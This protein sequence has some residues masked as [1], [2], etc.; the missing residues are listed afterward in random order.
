MA[1][2]TPE[3]T[4]AV[5]KF[6]GLLFELEGLAVNQH[7]IRMACPSRRELLRS[8]LPQSFE[9]ACREVYN[10]RERALEQVRKAIV[11]LFEED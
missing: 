6:Y 3:P 5:K 8:G 4:E 10:E 11:D 1:D 9:I 2:V 7:A